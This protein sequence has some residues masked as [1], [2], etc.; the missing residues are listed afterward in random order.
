MRGIFSSMHLQHFHQYT[1]IAFIFL[2]DSK[3]FN[4]ALNLNLLDSAVWIASHM[5]YYLWIKDES[6][7]LCSAKKNTS[8]L[9]TT[10]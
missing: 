4:A 5:K 6:A 10:F 3:Q 1:D 9:L 7:Q 8:S 2:I